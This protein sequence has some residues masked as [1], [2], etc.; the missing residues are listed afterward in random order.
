MSPFAE[1]DASDAFSPHA[2]AAAGLFQD[3][4][5]LL[6]DRAALPDAF[7]DLRTGLAGELTQRLSLYGIRLACVVPDLAAQPERFREFAREANRGDVIRFFEM[8]D[9]AERWLESTAE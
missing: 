4:R 7:F 3:G 9:A 8:R 2:V 6:I 5:A 1:F